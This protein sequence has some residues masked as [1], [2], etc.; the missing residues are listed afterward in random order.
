MESE[1][2]GSISA[3][4]FT[5]VDAY[6][7]D[8]LSLE[9]DALR[10]VDASIRDHELPQ[11][12]VSANQGRMLELFAHLINA[13]HILEIGTLAGYSTIFLARALPADGRIVT[14]EFD[15]KHADVARENIERAGLSDRV[16]LRV[17]KALDLL[18]VIAEEE[19]PP[20]DL[21]FIDA[22]KEPYAEYFEWAIRLSRPGAL[23]IADNVVRE[24]EILDDQS[25]D[26]RVIGAQRFLK[27]LAGNAHVLPAVLQTV[28][29][30]GYDGFALALVNKPG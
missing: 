14:L 22:D 8:L 25:T 26:E 20:F 15:P 12:S 27:A 19:L 6:L 30:K 29:A 28:G 21:V 1:V 24:G 4:K 23:I 13:K 9:D 7:A 2:T 5:A 11:I 18:P 16:E 10:A 17:G 3:D